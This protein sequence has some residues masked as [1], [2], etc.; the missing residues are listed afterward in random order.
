M[1]KEWQ[2]TYIEAIEALDAWVERANSTFICINIPPEASYA[3]V[4]EHLDQQDTTGTLSYE[5]EERHSRL[6]R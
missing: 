4:R 3:K 6:F 5:T 1:P 2:D